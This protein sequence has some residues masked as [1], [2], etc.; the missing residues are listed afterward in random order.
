[1]ESVEEFIKELRQKIEL[2]LEMDGHGGCMFLIDDSLSIHIDSETSRR[3]ALVVAEL[4][5]IPS[6]AYRQNIL[7]AALKS[8]GA[9]PP[10][11]GTLALS[12]QSDDLLLFEFLL[13]KPLSIDQAMVFLDKFV[14]KA[15]VWHEALKDGSVPET[16]GPKKSP[17]L[18][19]L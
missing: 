15:F 3:F 18:F 14:E 7:E 1:M 8:N 19:G 13:L 11:Y 4:G 6:G 16:S 10:L 17:R 2:P 5:S 12:Q 9:Q